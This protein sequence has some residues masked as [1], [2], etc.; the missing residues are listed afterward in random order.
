MH[1]SDP[2]IDEYTLAA[3]L[4]GTLAQQ[5]REEVIDYLAA[6]PDARDV[7]RM[8]AGA[9]EAA[10]GVGRVETGRGVGAVAAARRSVRIRRSR[11]PQHGSRPSRA[12]EAGRYLAAT[13]FVGFVGIALGLSFGPPTDALRSPLERSGSEMQVELSVPGPS[14]QWSAVEEVY[15]YRLVVWDPAEARVAGAY[16][17]SGSKLEADHPIVREMHRDLEAGRRYMLRIDAIDARN[18]LIRSSKALE[19]VF[20]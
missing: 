5:R 3:F 9:F 13:V 15:R 6:N 11:R 20:G 18:R 10:R 14:L 17:T 8:A 2:V 7:L 19:F 12:T 1:D 4:A 16:E